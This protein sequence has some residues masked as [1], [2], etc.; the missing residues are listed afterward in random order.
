MAL[1]P[2]V[3]KQLLDWIGPLVADQLGKAGWKSSESI[4]AAVWS[5]GA[6]AML[7]FDV[8]ITWTQFAIACLAALVSA[9]SILRRYGTK[10]QIVELAKNA[11]AEDET[12]ADLATI[13]GYTIDV[14]ALK[15]ADG[16]A[17]GV[18]RLAD[19]PPTPEPAAPEGVPA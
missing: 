11:I 17:C 13:P 6:G 8:D 2:A 16:V 14:R 15:L 1:S 19:Y 7:A 4:I 18:F 5:I 3:Q 10:A 12:W 9:A